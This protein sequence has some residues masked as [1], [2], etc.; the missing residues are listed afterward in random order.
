MD[1][2]LDVLTF[3]NSNEKVFSL[4]IW[5]HFV[6]GNRYWDIGIDE[7]HFTT[8]YGRIDEPGL[9]QRTEC[10][11]PSEAQKNADRLIYKK[12][13]QG[14]HELIEGVELPK[15]AEAI[16]PVLPTTIGQAS[17]RIHNDTKG[18]I[19]SRQP[20]SFNKRD[21]VSQAW[22]RIE[23]WLN[24]HLPRALRLLNNPIRVEDLANFEEHLGNP[25]PTSL[26]ESYLIHDGQSLMDFGI[27]YGFSLLSLSNV[28]ETLNNWISLPRV[29]GD[30]RCF[31]EATIRKLVYDSKWLPLA[32]DFQGNYLLVDLVPDEKGTVGQVF[33]MNLH[34]KVRVLLAHDW[35]HFLTDVADELER[36]NFLLKEVSRSEHQLHL[37][38]P[39]ENDGFHTMALHWS[40]AKLALTNLT[41]D[42]I[43]TWQSFR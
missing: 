13:G 15:A 29:A 30:F 20:D 18:E 6:H 8:R 3:P 40:K 24:Y 34:E 11:S 5:R 35:A 33:L 27:F 41:D 32:K 19:A 10:S 12:L 9:E 38:W 26:R 25:L 39:G 43:E 22:E 16:A 36:G 2:K 17:G 1:K 28:T 31:P 7:N 37:A 42:E 23:F 4:K 14:Y 21:S